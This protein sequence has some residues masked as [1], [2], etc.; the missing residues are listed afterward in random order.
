MSM[1]LKIFSSISTW[2]HTVAS[3]HKMADKNNLAVGLQSLSTFFSFEYPDCLSSREVL[4]PFCWS[5]E[6]IIAEHELPLH[7]TPDFVKHLT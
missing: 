5:E 1:F 7:L 2:N 4:S 6:S 3:T